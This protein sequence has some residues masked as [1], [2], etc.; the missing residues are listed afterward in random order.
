MKGNDT[1]IED[2]LNIRVIHLSVNYH[3]TDTLEFRMT[4]SKILDIGN[5]SHINQSCGQKSNRNVKALYA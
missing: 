3:F 2:L 1:K 5:L 4:T